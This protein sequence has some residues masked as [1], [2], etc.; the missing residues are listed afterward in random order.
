MS[1]QWV[2]GSNPQQWGMPP[3]VT[4][5]VNQPNQGWGEWQSMQQA[6]AMHQQQFPPGQPTGYHSN[7]VYRPPQQ[8]M[9]QATYIQEQLAKAREEQRVREMELQKRRMRSMNVAEAKPPT[10]IDSLIG[11][12]DMSPSTKRRPPTQQRPPPT[13]TAPQVAQVKPRAWTMDTAN[14][15]GVFS[16]PQE[17]GDDSFGE[18]QGLPPP[19]QPSGMGVVPTSSYTRPIPSVSGGSPVIGERYRSTSSPHLPRVH[20]QPVSSTGLIPS[21]F[22][23]LY[24]EVYNTCLVDGSLSTELLFP[25]LMSSHLPKILLGK[26]WQQVNRE[27]PGKLSQTELFVLL[28]LIGLI[29]A[30]CPNPTFT[31][32]QNAPA[33]PVPV[34]DKMRKAP[35]PQPTT[36]HNDF[37][38]FQQGF[39]V[40]TMR[41]G[42]P[43][44]SGISSQSSKSSFDTSKL[45]SSLSTSTLSPLV[46]TSLLD[47]VAQQ[48][49]KCRPI[50][51]SAEVPSSEF[52]EFKT[53]TTS[54]GVFT[55]LKTSTAVPTISNSKFGEFQ[56]ATT[57]ADKYEVFDVLKT[58]AEVPVI[59]NSEF[60]EFKTATTA[61]K[62]GVFDVLKTSTEVPVISNSEF[63]EFKT[64]T[65][66]ADKYGV[67]DVL[68]TSTEVPVISDKT[69]G[70][71]EF[72]S[73]NS[74]PVISRV[75]TTSIATPS[76]STLSGFGTYPSSGNPL[77]ELDTLVTS[78]EHTVNA[79]FGSFVS[80]SMST[81]FANF[82]TSSSNTEG[83]ANFT[84]AHPP[85][86]T[87]LSPLD[88][89]P[90]L[91]QSSPAV[92]SAPVVAVHFEPSA[93][94]L[95][96]VKPETE[97]KQMKSLT[98]LEILD[99][100]MEA[101]LLAKDTFT[102]SLEDKLLVPE[103]LDNFGVFEAFGGVQKL[104]SDPCEVW[105]KCLYKCG[106]VLEACVD[107]IGGV[108]EAGLKEEIA[109]SEEGRNKL[110][111]IA[112]VYR[113]SRRVYS[114][115]KGK[116]PGAENAEYTRSVQ[117][118]WASL[119]AL[120]PNNV[121]EELYSETTPTEEGV[122]DVSDVLSD[123][124]SKCSL[125]LAGKSVN[126]AARNSLDRKVEDYPLT[127]LFHNGQTYHASCANF[128]I[129]VVQEELPVVA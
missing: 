42:I 125:C 126:I 3:P 81:S 96:L 67:F 14:F 122:T 93:A 48:N 26:L 65:T 109:G 95:D 1:N 77:G 111:G 64:A 7:Q 20:P 84:Q 62:Y 46:N 60:G 112:E 92:S 89:L 49:D 76:T 13:N 61:D 37:E 85:P 119:I 39:S 33:P 68:K 53:A 71:G 72:N 22:P 12:S 74:Q 17:M 23:P 94:M 118:H 52:G 4:A 51:T 58:S 104:T 57:S 70:F 90:T 54:A 121:M 91:P 56:T 47:S 102:R 80:V 38:S 113:L 63:G 101:R 34:M 8:P 55:A 25:V 100:E 127:L 21:A 123:S 110:R 98:G 43:S 129:N 27:T 99:A 5:S 41:T 19:S 115:L 124:I 16:V 88:G 97:T 107:V 29:Q 116:E 78:K 75:L 24:M 40:P 30:G 59:S 44:S 128:W 103:N 9:N 15:Q 35:L 50:K 117:A 106:E 66:S 82:N 31:D 11:L 87:T 32:L 6:S 69:V 18:F 79:E 108:E 2:P 45:V 10:S 114:Y 120:L 28:G 36:T 73:G 83:W 86:T 105:R